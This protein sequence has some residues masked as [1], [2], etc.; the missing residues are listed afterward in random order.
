MYLII[1][2]ILS[3]FFVY[4]FKRNVNWLFFILIE[5]VFF[6][7]YVF[8]S[9]LAYFLGLNTHYVYITIRTSISDANYIDTLELITYSHFVIIFSLLFSSLLFLNSKTAGIPKRYITNGLANRMLIIITLWIIFSS[10]V[11]YIFGVGVMGTIGVRLPFKISG[12]LYYSRIVLLPILFL[13]IFEKAISSLNH[14]L[15]RNAMLIFIFLA[16]SEILVRTTKGPFFKL[17]LVSIFLYI[18]TSLSI[19]N[20]GFKVNKK[21][22]LVSLVVAVLLFPIIEVYR[23]LVVNGIGVASIFEIVATQ[24]NSLILLGLER[25]FHRLVGFTQLSGLVAMGFHPNDISQMFDYGSV[26]RFY[27]ETYLGYTTEG[28]L[29]SPS[30][31]GTA[32]I[33]GGNFYWFFIF[34]YM[35]IITALWRLS[36]SFSNLSLSIKCLLGYEIFNTLM[37]GTIVLTFTRISLY[38]IVAFLLEY[39]ISKRVH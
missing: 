10:F 29:S 20:L 6:L 28:H 27:T 5:L 2:S 17:I 3:L 39:Y 13:Y 9:V 30:F 35:F 8:K 36:S 1:N 34:I 14:R 19:S 31:L 22:V 25:F 21:Y 18:L 16:I 15:F 12:L 24:D 33:I 4:I 11:M 32:L 7:V 23:N 26:A 38:F 37:A